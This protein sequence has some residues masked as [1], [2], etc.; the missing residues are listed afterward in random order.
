VAGDT[1]VNANLTPLMGSEDFAFMLEQRPG[2]IM[3]IGN[4][5]TPGVHEAGYDFD[6]AALPYGIA[7]FIKLVEAGLSEKQNAGQA[8]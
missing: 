3:L 2:N 6:D 5:D 1:S 8:I 4:G 7:Y